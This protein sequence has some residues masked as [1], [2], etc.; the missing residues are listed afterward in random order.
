VCAYGDELPR[1]RTDH[2]VAEYSRSRGK[3]VLA[4]LEHT[5]LTSMRTAEPNQFGHV[6]VPTRLYS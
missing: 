4:W 5:V 1:L 2:T 3:A 6:E